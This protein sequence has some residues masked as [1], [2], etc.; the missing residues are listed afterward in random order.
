[1]SAWLFHSLV[2]EV[3]QVKQYKQP[4]THR[5]YRTMVARLRSQHLDCWLCNQP[6][7]YD[8]PPM[9]KWS[10]S[11]DHVVPLNKGGHIFGEL[12][13][14]HWIC[15]TSRQDKDVTDWQGKKPQ[16]SR[17]WLSSEPDNQE[18]SAI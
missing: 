4:R 3:L 13:A 11:A 16:P 5:R 12:K 6:I 9:S 1:M 7:D 2:L 8:A 14:S 15:N 10:F 17:D 18:G